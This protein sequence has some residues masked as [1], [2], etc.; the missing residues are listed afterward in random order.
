MS[1]NNSV[2]VLA[3]GAH[4]DDVEACA[5]G[6][7]LKAKQKGL[8]TGIVDLTLGEKGT[9][10]TIEIRKKEADEGAKI[11][12]CS[13]RENLEL[14]DGNISVNKENE[15]A[16]LEVIRKYRPETVLAPWLEDR[17]PDH[18][19][20]GKLVS[21]ASMYSGLA[22][23]E[24]EYER[25]RPKKIFYYML[26]YDFKP[27]FVV[28]ISDVFETKI[29]SLKAHK[30]QFDPNGKGVIKSYI[31]KPEF[32]EFWEIRSR[33]YGYRIGAKYGEP[34]KVRGGELG[35]IDIQGLITNC[36]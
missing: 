1:T 36:I 30:S 24:T 7:L 17:H 19:D 31:N 22:K 15:M 10:G 11:L 4:P 23:I 16:V 27:S 28:D 6:Y 26:H 34:Y 20:V 29:R 33:Y 3:F 18:E 14:P 32:L 21:K 2:D 5:G 25:W 9:N 8:T 12:G 35:V 13:F